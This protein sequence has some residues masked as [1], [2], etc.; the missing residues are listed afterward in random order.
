[1]KGKTILF[2]VVGTFRLL[3][4]NKPKEIQTPQ[5]NKAGNNNS[6][7]QK[8]WVILQLEEESQFIYSHGGQENPEKVGMDTRR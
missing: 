5:S 4:K 1:L 3:L 7:M 8:R 6:V 2:S